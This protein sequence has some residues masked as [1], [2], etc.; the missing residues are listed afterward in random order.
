MATVA[1]RP[2]KRPKRNALDGIK[3]REL[4]VGKCLTQ[5]QFAERVGVH[6]IDVSRYER[7]VVEP[8]LSVTRLLAAELGVPIELLL[9]GG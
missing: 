7:G 3:L 5:A 8:S 1:K 4:R 2:K 6:E 9:K